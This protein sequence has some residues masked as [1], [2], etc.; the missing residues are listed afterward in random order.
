ML[1]QTG[2]AQRAAI[3]RFGVL[4]QSMMKVKRGKAEDHLRMQS[5]SG[6]GPLKGS[7]DGAN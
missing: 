5:S 1:I 2:Q 3:D 4:E 7:G 6:K